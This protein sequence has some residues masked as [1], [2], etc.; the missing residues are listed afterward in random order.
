MILEFFTN[1]PKCRI[2]HADKELYALALSL[3]MAGKN[4]SVVCYPTEDDP[5]GSTIPS[6][7]LHRLI[8]G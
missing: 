4:V 3:Y 1:G 8:A 5:G 2:P 7:K 6:Y